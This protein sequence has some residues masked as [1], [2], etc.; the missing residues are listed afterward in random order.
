MMDRHFGP[1]TKEEERMMAMLAEGDRDP[2]AIMP[3]ELLAFVLSFRGG[4]LMMRAGHFP[5]PPREKPKAS[6][7]AA[8]K[9]EAGGGTD[10]TEY[11][12]LKRDLEALRVKRAA[13]KTSAAAPPRPRLSDRQSVTSNVRCV[14]Q[15]QPIGPCTRS[16][17]AA[18]ARA[19]PCCC[20]PGRLAA[21]C[22]ASA[23]QRAVRRRV[24]CSGRACGGGAGW[25]RSAIGG[26]RGVTGAGQRLGVGK[27]ATPG[28][29]VS[30]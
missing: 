23:Q 22:G 4:N 21:T 16:G 8:A 19:H 11:E 17:A 20:V 29:A 12:K 9:A 27:M 25:Q 28:V 15:A 3:P 2:D 13:S 6:E 24:A 30:Y 14:K 26:E 7:A 1:A 5:R 18:A 10:S